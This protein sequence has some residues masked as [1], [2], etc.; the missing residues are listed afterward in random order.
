MPKSRG[1]KPKKKRGTCGV[2]LKLSN[3][4][5]GAA[6]WN[7]IAG[8]ALM[9]LG[10]PAYLRFR[11]GARRHGSLAHFYCA[12]GTAFLGCRYGQIFRP[13][14]YLPKFSYGVCRYSEILVCLNSHLIWQAAKSDV[15]GG[16]AFRFISHKG[17]PY[18]PSSLPLLYA[19]GDGQESS[20]GALVAFRARF[21]E[22]LVSG[23][24]SGAA[25]PLGWTWF[26]LA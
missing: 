3:R 20:R 22:A 18:C 12:F 24:P 25:R 8:S 16:S 9:L 5:F 23:L 13:R 6:R 2:G 26:G 11:R 1:R 4:F 14:R 10:L 21:H 17:L 15:E 19:A 7:T